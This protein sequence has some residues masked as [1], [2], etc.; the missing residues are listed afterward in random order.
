MQ[1]L[2]KRWH[3]CLKCSYSGGPHEGEFIGRI[4]VIFKY[5]CHNSLQHSSS[6]LFSVLAFVWS[7]SQILQ[8]LR[9]VFDVREFNRAL[10]ML[11]IS[12]CHYVKYIA[13]IYTHICIYIHI[14]VHT[15]P[16]IYIDTHTR[17]I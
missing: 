16:H 7:Y 6:A 1:W 12:I 3:F 9:D 4:C 11:L 14:Y 2:V 17:T 8:F 13:C 15:H 5:R 10:C